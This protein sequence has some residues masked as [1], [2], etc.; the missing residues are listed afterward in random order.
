MLGVCEY[1]RAFYQFA[2]I[3]IRSLQTIGYCVALPEHRTTLRQLQLVCSS[4]PGGRVHLVH[5]RHAVHEM[6]DH[7][8]RSSRL[9]GRH[10]GRGYGDGVSATHPTTH[11]RAV[12]RC[13]LRLAR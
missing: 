6:G 10:L 12:V 3:Q 2:V 4:S 11:T 5:E 8:Q 7:V 13:A 9:I 1:V